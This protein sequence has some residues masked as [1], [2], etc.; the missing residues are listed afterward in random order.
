MTTPGY[1]TG[2]QNIS[3]QFGMPLY[4]IS[5]WLPFTGNYF[6]VDETNGSDGNT[7]GPQDPFKTLS[8][9]H[10]KCTAGNNDVVFFTGTIHQSSTLVW[11]KNN[12]HL[13]GLCDPVMRGKRARISVTGST[14]F[15]PLITVSAAGC[16][17]K[18]FGTFYGFDSATNNAICIT[19]TG[20]RNFYDCVEIMSF[21]DGT[22]TTGTANKTASRAL[23]I[24]GSTGECTF[25]DCVFGVDTESRG[26]ANYTVEIAG[27][28]PRIYFQRCFFEMLAGAATPAHLLIGAA[29]ID[30]Y[31]TFD[32]CIFNNAIKSTGTT[33]NQVANLNAAIGGLIFMKQSIWVGAT[34]WETSTTNQTYF[35]APV[36]DTSDPALAV[37][38]A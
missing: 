4:G 1:N 26:A 32:G 10:S 22:A 33:I 11:S 6:W 23:Y 16:W 14:A 5:G 24:N 18:N 28:A 9:A 36:Y 21:G 3:G 35:D 15:T 38:N 30:R 31:L 27:G 20:G 17:F 37:N 29:G 25:R 2:G 7:G 8:Q 12:T 13:I 19:D 34:H